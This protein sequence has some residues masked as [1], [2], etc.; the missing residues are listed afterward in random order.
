MVEEFKQFVEQIFPP[1]NILDKDRSLDKYSPFCALSLI[2]IE[3][4]LFCASFLGKIIFCGLQSAGKKATFQG[5]QIEIH[6]ED[7]HELVMALSK[8]DDCSK[9]KTAFNHVI[10]KSSEFIVELFCSFNKYELTL[11]Q[12]CSQSK[13]QGLF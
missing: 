8:V 4:E 11:R 2:H 6:L 7:C 10:S 9:T 3:G 13:R 5:K 1:E 12:T